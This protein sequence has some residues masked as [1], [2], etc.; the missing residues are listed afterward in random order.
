MEIR[1]RFRTDLRA[2]L[3]TIFYEGKRIERDI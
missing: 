3:L 1:K 2:Y